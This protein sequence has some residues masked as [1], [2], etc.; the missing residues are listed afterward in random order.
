MKPEPLAVTVV[1]ALVRVAGDTLARL[2]TGF[3]RAIVVLAVC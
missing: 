2:G 1:V 3:S